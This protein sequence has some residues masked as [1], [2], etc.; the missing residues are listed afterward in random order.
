MKEKIQRF[1]IGR[2]GN[3]YLN[4]FLLTLSIIM[5]ILSF[6]ATTKIISTLAW[7]LLIIAWFRM[8]SR[9][10]VR[11]QQENTVY[12]K[13]RSMVLASINYRK[14]V[15]TDRKTHNYFT[16]PNCKAHLRVPKGQG[17]ITIKCN[18]CSHKFERVS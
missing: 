5:I 4:R 9:N 16:C 8:L 13:Y 17:K 12:Y 11:R 15:W 7:L 3:D 14:K 6:L 18:N 10:I 2:Y 1:M